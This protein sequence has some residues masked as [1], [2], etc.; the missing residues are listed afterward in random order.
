MKMQVLNEQALN[1]VLPALLAL[2]RTA[3]AL[4]SR[5]GP[6]IKK[7]ASSAAKFMKDNPEFASQMADMVMS[8]KDKV[9]ELKDVEI[10]DADSMSQALNGEQGELLLKVLQDASSTV[11]EEGLADEPEADVDGVFEARKI[12]ITKRQLKKIVNEALGVS[13]LKIAK[14][15]LREIIKEEKSRLLKEQSDSAQEFEDIMRQIGE[16]VEE[17]FV[18]AGEP[19]AARRYWYNG[20]LT[21]IDPG[22]Y[23]MADFS[24]SMVDTLSE[25]SGGGD[26]EMMEMGYND[27][28]DGKKP[29]HP[30]N[31]YYMTNYRDAIR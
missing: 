24:Y 23:G 29:A 5:F 15:Q 26:E 28:A 13:K 9:P 21:R 22:Q 11:E 3:P 20:I 19:E 1:E 18:L 16:L 17:A 25:L 10:K 7:G 4:I 14:R 2:A 12:R 8:I 6:I 31:E 27:G 30:D